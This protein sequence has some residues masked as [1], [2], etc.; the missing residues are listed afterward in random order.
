[1]KTF[2]DTS[3][4][5]AVLNAKDYHYKSALLVW[6]KLLRKPEQLYMNNY[7]LVELFSLLQNHFGIE[8]VRI[9][10]NDVLP[11]IEIIWVTEILH[12][13]AVSALM[14]ANRKNLSLVDC[15]SFETIRWLGISQVFAF[16]DHFKEQ[17]FKVIPD[18]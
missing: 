12:Q 1:M 15:V 5:L 14:A 11:V 4:M 16:D 6:N 3:A 7:I 2:I 10:Q 9:F 17:G 18:S 13:Q 8:A